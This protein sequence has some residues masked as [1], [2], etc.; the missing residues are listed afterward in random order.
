MSDNRKSSSEDA[1]DKAGALAK[2]A[3]KGAFHLACKYFG[4]LA[5]VLLILPALLLAMMPDLIWNVIFHMDD[6]VDKWEGMDKEL[7]KNDEDIKENTDKY[8]QIIMDALSDSSSAIEKQ[9]KAHCGTIKINGK[10]YKIDYQGSLANVV[11]ETGFYEGMGSGSSSDDGGEIAGGDDAKVSKTGAAIAEYAQKWIGYNYVLGGRE[12][13]KGYPKTKGL[14]CAGFVRYCYKHAGFDTGAWDCGTLQDHLAKYQVG[15]RNPSHLAKGDIIIF[16][17]KTQHAHTAIYIGKGMIMSASSAQV[18]I[19][20]TPLKGTV[21]IHGG[22]YY[23]YRPFPS[24]TEKLT[25]TPSAGGGATAG[26]SRHNAAKEKHKSTKKNK[27]KKAKAANVN[28]PEKPEAKSSKGKKEAKKETKKETKKSSS[29]NKSDK[30]KAKKKD[31]KDKKSKDKKDKDK[32]EGTIKVIHGLPKNGPYVYKTL[33][34]YGYDEI[35][36]IGIMSCWWAES[37]FNPAAVNKQELAT[38]GPNYAGSGIAQ[39]TDTRNPPMKR[40]VSKK[41]GHGWVSLKWQVAYFQHEVKTSSYYASMRPSLANKNNTLFSAMHY[42]LVKY[43]GC[44]SKDFRSTR[45]SYA[46]KLYAALHGIDPDDISGDVV[47]DDG[48]GDEGGSGF[49]SGRFMG[50]ILSSFSVYEDSLTGG[51]KEKIKKTEKE[52]EDKDNAREQD[53]QTAYETELDTLYNSYT[54]PGAVRDLKQNAHGLVQDVKNAFTGKDEQYT[55]KDAASAKLSDDCVKELDDLYNKA[56]DSNMTQEQLEQQAKKIIADKMSDQLNSVKQDRIDKQEKADML[57]TGVG[58]LVNDIMDHIKRFGQSIF[59]PQRDPKSDLKNIMSGHTADFFKITYGKPVKSG[60]VYVYSSITIQPADIRQVM[61]KC[62]NLDPDGIYS[63]KISKDKN[64]KPLPLA[65]KHTTNYQ[66]VMQTTD[67]NMEMLYNNKSGGD[68]YGGSG[69]GDDY[70]DYDGSGGKL[71]WPCSH[72]S[73]SCEFGTKR[74]WDPYAKNG[75]SGMDIAVPAGTPVHSPGDGIVKFAGTYGGYGNCIMI[76][77]GDG[78]V[79]LFG[80]LR[81]IGVHKGQKVKTGKVIGKSGGV[82]GAPGSGFSNGPH[83]HFEVQKNGKP[84]NPRIFLTKKSK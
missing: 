76:S 68:G 83:L 50:E 57:D 72:S 71:K 84:V 7:K 67:D 79:S 55:E 66:E 16:G 82:K 29:N 38:H 34:S 18:G 13:H 39:W 48:A 4:T 26:Y 12:M 37:S 53:G 42:A 51:W 25:K 1:L 8:A 58:G 60:N 61:K 62:F 35:A 5:V 63:S 6:N 41:S 28:Q 81:K 32:K 59:Q 78:I 77:H 74:S 14:D 65:G 20:K 49:I 27:H 15:G 70:D 9:I 17:T 80:H 11:D 75:H 69:G 45:F 19:I 33:R 54:P 30:E 22:T 56:K 52:Q 43:E 36:A 3:A 21:N 64:G 10:I 40:W 73:I 47:G 23:A 44:D 46:K 31:S 2:M 24:D